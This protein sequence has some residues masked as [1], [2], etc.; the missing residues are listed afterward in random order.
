MKKFSISALF[1]GILLSVLIFPKYSEA[2]VMVSGYGTG[3]NIMW[4][5]GYDGAGDW[6]SSSWYNATNWDNLAIA[7]YLY[8]YP[9]VGE[10]N[11]LY[12]AVED[13]GG[14][15]GFLASFQTS[16]IFGET[17]SNKLLTDT[18][19]WEIVAHSGW[20]GT[21]TFNPTSLTAWTTPTSYGTNTTNTYW[22]FWTP[23][24]NIDPS[25]QWI[26]TDQ[27]YNYAVLHAQFT[28]V[29]EPMSLS[30]L[31][32]GLLGVIGVVGLRRRK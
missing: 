31:G 27:A 3:D 7:K 12:F 20:S 2:A 11:D 13:T 10:T 17:G 5:W 9:D 26:W 29:P 8:G 6:D 21:P 24:A 16:A 32:M 4:A 30:L 25:A 1:T 15:A 19:H 22:M 18:T 28:V 14:P 23:I